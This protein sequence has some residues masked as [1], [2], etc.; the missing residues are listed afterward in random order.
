[1]IADVDA[2]EPGAKESDVRGI[3]HRFVHA[4]ILFCC[5]RVMQMGIVDIILVLPTLM[6]H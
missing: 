6:L 1:M 4:R 2:L 3:L 5:C